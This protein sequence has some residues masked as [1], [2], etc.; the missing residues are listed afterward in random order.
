MN[1]HIQY[2]TDET[3]GK[4]AVL[5]PL[6]EWQQLLAEYNH[7]KQCATLKKGISDA[8]QEI[9]E[10]ESGKKPFVTLEEFLQE[11]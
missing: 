6:Q 10:I 5:I 2:L 11:C 9:R 7:L 3:G 8:F 4:T 1:L